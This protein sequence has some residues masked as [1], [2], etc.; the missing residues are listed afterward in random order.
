MVL[1]FV[2]P[3]VAALGSLFALLALTPAT[4][5]QSRPT[6]TSGVEAVVLDVSVLDKVCP[7]SQSQRL[8]C[9]E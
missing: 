9:P 4:A 3:R 8:P 2:A 1:H 7:T 6:F 5:Q